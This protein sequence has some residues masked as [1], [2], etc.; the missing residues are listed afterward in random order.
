MRLDHLVRSSAAHPKTAALLRILAEHFRRS[1]DAGA[2]PGDVSRVIIFTNL[3]ETVTAICEALRPHEPLVQARSALLPA[4]LPCPVLLQTNAG[5]TGLA[6]KLYSASP[7]PARLA[8]VISN[9][10]RAG[11]CH[12]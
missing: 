10:C 5:H 8:A 1:A 4:H 2:E 11:A 9:L 6:G 3:R 7:A 12:L